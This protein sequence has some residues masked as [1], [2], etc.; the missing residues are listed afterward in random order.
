M[1]SEE[2]WKLLALGFVLENKDS[3]LLVDLGQFGMIKF[4][5]LFKSPLLEAMRIKVLLVLV[6]LLREGLKQEQV[7]YYL[8]RG[9]VESGHF[10]E[11]ELYLF[12][13]EHVSEGYK[14]GFGLYLFSIGIAIHFHELILFKHSFQTFILKRSR[15][16]ADLA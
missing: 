1:L 10:V 15:R 3:Y 5:Q 16:L 8:G 7:V 2:K 6:V 14:L 12:V 4:I 13:A 11:D 9:A